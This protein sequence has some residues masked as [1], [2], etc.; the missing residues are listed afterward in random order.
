MPWINAVPDYLLKNIKPYESML[1]VL[2]E[3]GKCW[4]FDSKIH[5]KMLKELK[6]QKKLKRVKIPEK[7]KK[8]FQTCS[9]R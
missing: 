7:E 9:I 1:L 2:P 8:N 5:V 3:L 6:Y 4:Q